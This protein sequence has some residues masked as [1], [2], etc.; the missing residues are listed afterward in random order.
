MEVNFI[1]TC[2]LALTFHFIDMWLH[3]DWSQQLIENSKSLLLILL[4]VNILQPNSEIVKAGI[5]N[6]IGDSETLTNSVYLM[7]FYRSVCYEGAKGDL[8]FRSQIWS[9]I[10]MELIFNPCGEFQWSPEGQVSQSTLLT[11]AWCPWDLFRS[12]KVCSYTK[13]RMGYGKQ[14]KATTPIHP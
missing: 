8:D 11:S 3:N 4:Y 14:W 5:I 12:F 9:K 6:M 2:H 13:E 7:S 1:C 10:L